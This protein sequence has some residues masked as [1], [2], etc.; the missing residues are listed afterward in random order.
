M[1]GLP[2][3]IFSG[4]DLSLIASSPLVVFVFCMEKLALMI[5][6]KVSNGLWKPV[7]VSR[8]GPS[9][10]YLFFID[11]ILL[12]YRAS[13]DQIELVTESLK[14]FCDASGLRVN[15]DKSRAMCSNMVPRHKR[16]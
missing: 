16:T 2:A 13:N 15:V 8:G 6:S 10:S 3:T 1:L 5:Q 11:D 4:M 12:F 7:Q 9:I 14:E